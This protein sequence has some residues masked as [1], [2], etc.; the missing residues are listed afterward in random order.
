MNLRTISDVE[1]A[2]HA[3]QFAVDTYL[4]AKGWKYTC[5]NPASLWLWEKTLRD[6]RTVLVDSETAL[7]FCRRT[8]IEAD[9]ATPRRGRR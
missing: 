3:L 7:A 1:A 4:R 5:A 2:T 8:E 6:G 9:G